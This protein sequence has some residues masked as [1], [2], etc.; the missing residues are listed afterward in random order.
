MTD[1]LCGQ[2]PI[3]LLPHRLFIK[4]I[5]LMSVCHYL[6]LSQMMRVCHE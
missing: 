2:Q 3:Q 4:I 5:E 1:R 6:F